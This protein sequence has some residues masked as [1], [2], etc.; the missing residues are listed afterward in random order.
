LFLLVI[1]ALAEI[2]RRNDRLLRVINALA[3]AAT[4]A[5]HRDWILA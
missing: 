2:Q 5:R 3:D 4:T 1:P